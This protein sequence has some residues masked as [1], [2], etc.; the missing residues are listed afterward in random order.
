VNAPAGSSISSAVLDDAPGVV[1]VSVCFH[2]SDSVGASFIKS[3]PQL[4]MATI[5]GRASGVGIPVLWE[6]DGVTV[7]RECPAEWQEPPACVR[8]WYTS[9]AESCN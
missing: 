9:E 1:L 3:S 7:G 4:L 6:T 2:E 8:N 5:F